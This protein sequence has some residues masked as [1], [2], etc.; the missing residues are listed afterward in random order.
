MRTKHYYKLLSRVVI[1]IYFFQLYWGIL[2][3]LYNTN[4]KLIVHCFEKYIQPCNYHPNQRIQHFHLPRRFPFISPKGSQS[5][6][7]PETMALFPPWINQ[8]F[9]LWYK[10]SHTICTL[11][12]L[13]PF[14]I[15]FQWFIHYVVCVNIQ[16]FLLLKTISLYG[17]TTVCPFKQRYF[18]K[19]NINILYTLICFSALFF[20]VDFSFETISNL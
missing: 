6:P 3:I 20:K 1:Y 8:L 19:Q 12:Y 10:K 11:L 4:I 9:L 7:C 17:Y 14:S 2:Y 5:L 15:M 13:T 16:S 18:C